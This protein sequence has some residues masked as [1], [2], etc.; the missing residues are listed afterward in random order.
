ML[1]P[2]LA[3]AIDGFDGGRLIWIPQGA[4]V[5]FPLQAAPCGDGVLI[6]VVS[7]MVSPSLVSA[8]TAMEPDTALPLRTAAIQGTYRRARQRPTAAL[9][10]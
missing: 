9:A 8:I 2:V 10:C 5:G 4:L 1:E 6:D 3:Q 7:V